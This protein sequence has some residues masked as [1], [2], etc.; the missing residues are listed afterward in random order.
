MGGIQI[1]ML[2]KNLQKKGEFGLL[3][4]LGNRVKIRVGLN[5]GNAM[6]GNKISD[7]TGVVISNFKI[8]SVPSA[9]LSQRDFFYGDPKNFGYP[10]YSKDE[11]KD[12][13]NEGAP[14]VR[15]HWKDPFPS[16]IDVPDTVPPVVKKVTITQDGK[17]RYWGEWIETK[18]AIGPNNVQV[19]VSRTW[20]EISEKKP[21]NGKSPIKIKVEFSEDM[22]K[23]G[24]A[25]DLMKVT[26]GK[27]V[28]YTAYKFTGNWTNNYTWEGSCNPPK[29]SDG[30]NTIRIET[31][32]KD[33]NLLDG[34]PGSVVGIIGGKRKNYEDENGVD[35]NKGG[36]DINHRFSIKTTPPKIKYLKISQ[37][38]RR[39]EN[40]LITIYG[41]LKYH[42]DYTTG[43]TLVN[44]PIVVGSLTG[45]FVVIVFD[46]GIDKEKPLDVSFT[47]EPHNLS[48]YSWLGTYTDELGTYTGDIWFGEI[49]LPPSQ[50][51]QGTHTLSIKGATDLAGN[52][53]D[54]NPE[55][56]EIEPDISNKF[57]ILI[58]DIAYTL[59]EEEAGS[60]TSSVYALNI[61]SGDS[62]KITGGAYPQFFPDGDH[63]AIIGGT[64]ETTNIDIYKIKIDGTILKNLTND[65]RAKWEYK[66]NEDGSKIVVEMGDKDKYIEMW[67]L[68]VEGGTKTL[69]TSGRPFDIW[70]D[71]VLY[72]D[73]ALWIMDI[74]GE[75]EKMLV[76][77]WDKTDPLHP[78]RTWPY[79]AMFAPSG[80]IFYSRSVWDDPVKI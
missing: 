33:G 2:T 73:G 70:K 21:C 1:Q 28:P 30:E 4:T 52:V 47:S 51:Y 67:V 72:T 31:Q 60:I 78:L 41:D 34:K 7:A 16:S 3:E 46:S 17:E 55:T 8:I 19:V 24:K 59:R 43:E 18:E 39:E 75:N 22:F 71:K 62:V 49:Y 15:P 37:G 44:K 27:D 66:I 11:K 58:P 38:I 74:T 42:K 80:V 56:E 29:D 36:A 23:D 25:P 13:E 35:N 53:F 76:P 20:K 50:S 40:N 57:Y 10:F 77:E 54:A 45:C 68:D 12:E 32:D 79:T 48:F 9:G 69:L 64:T 63:L 6:Y 61:E 5:D 26:F 65:V 14:W